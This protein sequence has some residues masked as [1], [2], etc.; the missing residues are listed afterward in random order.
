MNKNWAIKITK[1]AKQINTPAARQSSNLL[2]TPYKYA[3]KV[4]D[5]FSD[6]KPHHPEE[7]A[8]SIN[9]HLFTVRHILRCLREGGVEFTE[10]E[11]QEWQ[12]KPAG[13]RPPKSW[14]SRKIIK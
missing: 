11:T 6:G 9:V 2:E 10:T 13:G 3:L 8:E 5:A 1:N 12:P 4:L 14:H 7:I